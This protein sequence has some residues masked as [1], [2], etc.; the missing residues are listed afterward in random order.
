MKI[1]LLILFLGMFA[2][3]KTLSQQP[4]LP[5]QSAFLAQVE[6]HLQSGEL[7]T[8]R[9]LTENYLK[10]HPNDEAALKVMAEIINQETAR[11]KAL[12]EGKAEE[13]Y[14]DEEKKIQVKNWLERSRSFMLNGNYQE[15]IEA[16][17]MV[18]RFDPDSEEASSLID[19]IRKRALKEGKHELVIRGEMNRTESALRIKR[20]LE[21]TETYMNA[22]Q[23]GMARLTIQKLLLLDPENKQGLRLMDEIQDQLNAKTKAAA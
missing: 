14:G 6:S 18:F 12:L 23:W 9:K 7:Y 10:A 2:G 21:Q 13:E 11:E 1:N 22:G 15:A 17:E 8:A 3:C 16:A 4:A 19:D 20:Y 5:A